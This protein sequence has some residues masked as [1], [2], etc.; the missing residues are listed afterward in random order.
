MR[1]RSVLRPLLLLLA[2]AGP[3]NADTFVVNTTDDTT[4]GT[5]NVAHCSLREALAAAG[6][7]VGA[8]H[9]INFAIPGA[10]VRTI[11]VGTSLPLSPSR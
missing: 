1:I 9:V 2:L 3:A 10:G 7:A 5:C 8:P 11:N 6:S 4:D